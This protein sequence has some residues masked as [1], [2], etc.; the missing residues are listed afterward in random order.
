MIGEGGAGAEAADAALFKI[1]HRFMKDWLADERLAL[2][3]D[4]I[5]GGGRGPFGQGDLH[6]HGGL[7]DG[8]DGALSDLVAERCGE[9]QGEDA[10]DDDAGGFAGGPAIDHFRFAGFEELFDLDEHL[11]FFFDAGVA[12]G[13]GGGFGAGLFDIGGLDAQH[14][15]VVA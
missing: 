15:N 9:K 2:L 7:P 5:A 14:A 8:A 3:G 13:V 10:G 12:G 1:A 6:A 4:P 11:P